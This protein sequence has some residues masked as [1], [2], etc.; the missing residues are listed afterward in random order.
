MQRANTA[1]GTNR[2]QNGKVSQNPHVTLLD[3]CPFF[4]RVAYRF[5]GGMVLDNAHG[6]D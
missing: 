2:F 6:K 4:P 1:S 5:C 3:L